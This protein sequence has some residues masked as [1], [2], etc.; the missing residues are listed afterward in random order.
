MV[1]LS[2]VMLNYQRVSHMSFGIFRHHGPSRIS[3]N[4]GDLQWYHFLRACEAWTL[5][6][7]L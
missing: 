7:V 2:I 6:N 1:D 5:K 3:N 4:D